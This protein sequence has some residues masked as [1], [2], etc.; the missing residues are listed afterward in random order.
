[1][2]VVPKK[3]Y[4]FSYRGQATTLF[5]FCVRV[6]LCGLVMI[7]LLVI[8]II[9]YHFIR[10]L[11][12]ISASSEREIIKRFLSDAIGILALVE[13]TKTVMDYLSVGR[14]RV[15][16]V[17]D[18]VLILTLKDVILIWLDE[19][20]FSKVASLALMIAVLVAAR[21]LAIQVSPSKKH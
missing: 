20:K 7:T 14:V 1:M 4:R 2:P 16:E 10:D 6:L 11:P 18:T 5:W 21:S 8:G 19:P 17:I 12:E 3:S 15:S 9:L 13:I